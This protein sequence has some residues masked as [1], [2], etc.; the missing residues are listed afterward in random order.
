[1]VTWAHHAAPLHPLM[2]VG[3]ESHGAFGVF[4]PVGLEA[5]LDLA[6]VPPDWLKRS[7]GRPM[8]RGLFG[9]VFFARNGVKKSDLLSIC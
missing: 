9:Q 5:H 8:A 7:G 6:V 3:I 2:A 1:M 4:L